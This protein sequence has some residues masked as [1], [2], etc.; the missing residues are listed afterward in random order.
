MWSWDQS[1]TKS[2]PTVLPHL[3]QSMTGVMAHKRWGYLRLRTFYFSLYF[4]ALGPI[5]SDWAR[6]FSNLLHTFGNVV[7]YLSE[8]DTV[9][10][11][12]E[13]LTFRCVCFN[14]FV[15][16]LRPA[17]FCLLAKKHVPGFWEHALSGFGQVSSI[18]GTQRVPRVPKGSQRVPFINFL[19]FIC[20]LNHRWAKEG[21][22]E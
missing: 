8:N 13:I 6:C 15:T 4:Q 14:L 16:K 11:D 17:G 3:I 22:A 21:T 20:V 10:S 18:L 7:E 19:I 1:W 9:S 12:F 2:I 5:S